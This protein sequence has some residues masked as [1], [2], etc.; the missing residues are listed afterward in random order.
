MSLRSE[1][2]AAVDEVVQPAPELEWRVQRLVL[3]ERNGRSRSPRR[4]WVMP[5]RGIISAAAAILILALVTT[6]LVGGRLWAMQNSTAKG[7][8][9]IDQAVLKS[10]EERPVQ[11]PMLAT[12]A[13]CPEGPISSAAEG[14]GGPP[15]TYGGGPVYADRA[16]GG[17][18]Y[19]SWGTWIG[20]GYYIDPAYKGPVLIRA[21]DLRSGAVVAFKPGNPTSAVF[22]PSTPA[23]QVIGQD[24]DHLSNRVVDLHSEDFISVARPL[25][26]PSWFRQ[27]FA[28]VGYAAGQSG[29]IGYQV[30]GTSFTEVF[31]I[32][33]NL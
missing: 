20:Q 26:V 1:I 13:A 17:H 18:S 14:R 25:E 16:G 22:D 7:Q 33:E 31:V 12:G 15:L 23:G 11:L 10:L 21:R 19:T 8:P 5:V 4:G 30:D 3:E 32:D 27:S 28:E 6:L 2:R 9:R 24:F 29:C